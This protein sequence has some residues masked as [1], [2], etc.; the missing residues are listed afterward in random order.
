MKALKIGF[1]NREGWTK[2]GVG[3]TE[4]SELHEYQTTPF[5][6]KIRRRISFKTYFVMR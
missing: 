5:S 3:G 6:F 1:Q 4:C 2:M